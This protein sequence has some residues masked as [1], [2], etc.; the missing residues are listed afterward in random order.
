MCVSFY[1]GFGAVM[2]ST[3]THGR[4]TL[5]C[6]TSWWIAQG[7][8]RSDNYVMAFLCITHGIEIVPKVT[9]KTCKPYRERVK[10]AN[11]PC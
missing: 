7:W 9:H 5:A 11:R 6:I 8:T 2:T 4:A 10:G 3:T 1:L